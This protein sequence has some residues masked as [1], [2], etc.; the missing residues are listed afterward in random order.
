M[1][2]RPAISLRDLDG[3]GGERRR[4]RKKGRRRRPPIGHRPA[5]H[6]EWE[7]GFERAR[8]PRDEWGPTVRM[9]RNLR[10]QA[11]RGH[12]AAVVDLRPGLDLVAEIPEA[13]TRT[14]FGL[15]PLLAPLIVTA[16][17]KALDGRKPAKGPL[18]ALFRQGGTP[19]A[20]PGPVDSDLLP[21]PTVDWVDDD[22]MA[23]VLGCDACSNCARGRR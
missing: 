2:L 20:L 4:R 21:A 1:R 10:I 5:P 19:R 8:Q 6:A 13:V 22:D 3:F 14:E 15:A 16:A 9:G 18:T 7:L 23:E 12:R 17:K 11:A